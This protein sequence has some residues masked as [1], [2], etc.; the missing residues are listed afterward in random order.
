M[1]YDLNKK[2]RKSAVTPF[3]RGLCSQVF[4]LEDFGAVPSP[5]PLE[6]KE[7]VYRV[8]VGGTQASWL[9]SL[10][11]RARRSHPARPSDVIDGVVVRWLMDARREVTAALR[12][13]LLWGQRDRLLFSFHRTIFRRAI[14]PSCL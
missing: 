5:Q 12:S 9:S 7:L 6:N 10:F 3:L 14:G 11:R 8:W 13:H 4:C 1:R 2:T